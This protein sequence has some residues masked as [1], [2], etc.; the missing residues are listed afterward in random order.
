MA[1]IVVG[2][3]T[4]H[5]PQMSTPPSKWH[6]FE[7]R[8]RRHPQLLAEPPVTYDELVARA[9]VGLKEKLTEE[10]WTAE[11]ERAQAGLKQ[12]TEILH[13][14]RPDIIV[15]IGDDQ[16]EHLLDDNMPQFCVY[17]G[18]TVERVER[19]RTPDRAG[20]QVGGNG[21]PPEEVRKAF[22]AAPDLGRHVI[23]SLI[24]QG[25]DIAVSN[26]LKSD[27]GLGH[28]FTFF[29]NR[30][31]IAAEHPL[32]MLPIMV[33]CFYPPNQPPPARCYAFGQA[34]RKA[35]EGWDSDQRVAIIGSGGL[36]HVVLDEE[37]DRLTLEAI[38]QKDIELIAA[39][40]E[41]R[42]IRGTSENRNWIVVAGAME[43]C[44]FNLVDY[45]PAYRNTAAMGHGLSFAVWK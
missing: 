31:M 19:Q 17:Y 5:G 21:T 32:P 11:F 12:I 6:E 22:P 29:Y 23:K 20:W 35:I 1:Q 41:E 40:P 38:R 36:S 28:A 34:L 13:E 18:D 4:P 10:T 2:M 45:I 16:H 30:D 27:V 14:A 25:F 33:N 9:P 39:L 43:P 37:V 42:L 44:E 3:T 24:H 26:Q 15:G 8:D 7:E